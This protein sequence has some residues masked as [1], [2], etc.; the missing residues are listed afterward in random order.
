VTRGVVYAE[1]GAQPAVEEITLDP[2]GE[3][4]VQVRIEACG[5]CHT[6]LHVVEADWRSRSCSGTREPASS[7]RSARA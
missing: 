5:V 3:H 7:R 6:D 4:E 1:P 2:P